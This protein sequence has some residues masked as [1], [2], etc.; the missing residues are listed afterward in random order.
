MS[1]TKNQ[2]FAPK[3]DS[4]AD[5]GLGQG[6]EHKLAP[7]R[8]WEETLDIIHQLLLD[9]WYYLA[10]ISNTRGGLFTPIQ[11]KI[12]L[13][14]CKKN[15]PEELKT[16][17]A[18]RSGTVKQLNSKIRKQQLKVG[19]KDVWYFSGTWNEFPKG[20]SVI[21][22]LQ[23]PRWNKFIAS[24]PKFRRAFV[25]LDGACKVEHQNQAM[26]LINKIIKNSDFAKNVLKKRKN[27]IQEQTRKDV[28]ARKHRSA[29]DM[30]RR[31]KE[32]TQYMETLTVEEKALLDQYFRRLEQQGEYNLKLQDLKNQLDQHF[33]LRKKQ[34]KKG[35][36]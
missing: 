7:H 17:L 33:L 16:L 18:M 8:D 35:M 10:T 2:Y 4:M 15:I 9:Q 31:L 3:I 1:K 29:P 21:E 6:L 25:I 13:T 24:R 5:P 34:Y 12:N 19:N 14:R 23:Q 26:L 11:K 22:L 20:T 30:V 36:Q 28:K 32:S 27:P